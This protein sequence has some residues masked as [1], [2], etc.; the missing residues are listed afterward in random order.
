M[1]LFIG[2]AKHMEECE[3]VV[4]AIVAAT[5]KGESSLSVEVDDDFSEADYVYIQKRVEEE[6][7]G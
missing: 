7:G 3:K 5:R 2:Y 4:A 6:L 1:S